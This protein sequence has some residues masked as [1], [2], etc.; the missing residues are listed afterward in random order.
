MTAETTAAWRACP[1]QRA[2][3]IRLAQVCEAPGTQYL[4]PRHGHWLVQLYFSGLYFGVLDVIE[5]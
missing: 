4:L 5:K 1:S 2:V 3:S